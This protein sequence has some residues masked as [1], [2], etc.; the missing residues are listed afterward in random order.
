MR[1]RWL[2]NLFLLLLVAGIA[3]FLYLRPEKQAEGPVKHPLTELRPDGVDRIDIQFPAKAPVVLQKR[4]GHWFLAEPYAAR[5]SAGFVNQLLNLLY[6]RST[7]KFAADE[8]HRFGL[9]SPVLKLKFGAQ[10]FAFGTYNPLS[11]EQYVLHNGAVYLVPSSFSELAGTQVVEMLD[12]NLL[13]PQEQVAGF[14]FSR[15]EQWE[16]SGLR[17]EHDG[18]Q[19]RVTKPAGKPADSAAIDGWFRDS[20]GNFSALSVE[21]YKT[22]ARASYPSFEV[23]LRDGRTVHFDKVQESPQLL[24]YRADEGMLYH[25]APD[26][27]FVLLNPPVGFKND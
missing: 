18:Q 26:I 14:D 21:P 25:V 8:L 6:T 15:L 24:L 17:V 7:A 16:K 2:I 22:E 10:E 23:M 20:W 27:G 9:D 13:A 1:A 3:A 4:D 19:W 11:S 5:A 12:K